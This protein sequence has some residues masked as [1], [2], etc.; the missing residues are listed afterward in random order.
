MSVSKASEE[1]NPRGLSR[2][3]WRTRCDS[4]QYALQESLSIAI[5]DRNTAT[6][7]KDAITKSRHD[8]QADIQ[9]LKAKLSNSEDDLLKPKAETAEKDRTIEVRTL[10][11]TSEDHLAD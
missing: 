2:E 6:D 5:R 11:G 4:G 1:A 9:T 8:L 10:Q 3:A 7:E